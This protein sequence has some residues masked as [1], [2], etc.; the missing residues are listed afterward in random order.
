MVADHPLLSLSETDNKAHEEVTERTNSHFP[1]R[2]YSHKKKSI[3]G[4]RCGL[5]TALDTL[6]FM[7]FAI[8]KGKWLIVAFLPLWYNGRAT[9]PRQV[10]K[11]G[12]SHERITHI[13]FSLCFGR[14]SRLLHLQMAGRRR[15]AGSQPWD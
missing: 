10:E 14:C 3:K 2:D 15:I 1:L 4:K 11:G 6:F 13:F 7:A 5:S 12:E 8:I 9:T